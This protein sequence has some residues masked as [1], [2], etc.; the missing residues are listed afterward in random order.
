LIRVNLN[1]LPAATI[2]RGRA[3]GWKV[4]IIMATAK[5]TRPWR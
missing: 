2:R 3:V 5:A 4:W 1:D